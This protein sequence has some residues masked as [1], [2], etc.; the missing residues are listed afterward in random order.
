MPR[1]ARTL[2]DEFLQAM[3]LEP[4]GVRA[5]ADTDTG[6]LAKTLS[7][8]A[9][10]TP[11]VSGFAPIPAEG[12]KLARYPTS[13]DA[14]I[15]RA[16]GFG[17]GEPS[18]AYIE[19][20]AG[21][22][23]GDKKGPLPMEGKA[24]IPADGLY[25]NELIGRGFQTP[26]TQNVTPEQQS[27][28]QD[29]NT[30]AALA[31]NYSPVAALGFVPRDITADVSQQSKFARQLA[32][33]TDPETGRIF[34]NINDPSTIG[35]ESMHRGLL[36]LM[37]NPNLP[38]HL[39]ERIDPYADNAAHESTVRQLVASQLGDPE[40]I[41]TSRI[42]QEQAAQGPQ[43]TPEEVAIL[44]RLAQEEIKNRRPRGPR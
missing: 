12:P 30:K 23:F 10:G 40:G 14:G 8:A 36:S 28:M 16:G 4:S 33:A 3:R 2:P 39:R 32:G 43:W 5:D 9:T 1:S 18:S 11:P 44:N 34:Y 20:L 22:I 38:V 41:K 6:T 26:T 19:G 31:V 35:H 15:A 17:Y 37:N 42:A 29:A 24:P 7:K 13:T 27:M 21:R 25:L